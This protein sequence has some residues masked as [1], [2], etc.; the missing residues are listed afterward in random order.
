MSISPRNRLILTIAA[1]ALVVLA[2]VAL[3][4]YPQFQKLSALN[5]EV[6]AASAQAEAAKL[7]LEARRGFKDRAIETDAKWL[8]LMNQVPDTPDLASLIIELQDTAFDS[9]VQVVSVT[10]AQPTLVSTFQSIPVSV[11]ILGTW[12][13]TVDY[14]Q[15]LLKL[16]RGLRV[17]SFNVKVTNDAATS[18][19][20]NASLPPYSVDTVIGV[21]AYMIP[22]ATATPTAAPAAPAQ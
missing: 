6:A 21:E 2:L 5:S 18:N 3:L 16:D 12:S 4:L 1:A 10:P 9:G 17:I 11:E 22:S 20:R 14:A 8:R 7:Q 15:S 13:D 19:V